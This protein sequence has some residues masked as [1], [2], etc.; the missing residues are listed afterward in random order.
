MSAV[1]DPLNLDRI[2]ANFPLPRGSTLSKL[3]LYLLH[4]EVTQLLTEY[5]V[6]FA[7]ETPPGHHDS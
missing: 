6:R 7:R 3:D 5:I 2:V 4:S 1:N